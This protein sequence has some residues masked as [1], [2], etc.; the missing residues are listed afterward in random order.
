MKRILILL[1]VLCALCVSCSEKETLVPVTGLEIEQETINIEVGQSIRL[2]AVITPLDASD[3]SV[4][5]LSEK[6]KIVTVDQD[7]VI[8][9]VKAGMARIGVITADEKYYDLCNV[10]VEDVYGED[11]IP[12]PVFMEC[13]LAAT[14]DG[15]DGSEKIDAN[16][17]GRISVSEAQ[18]VTGI[19]VAGM[20]IADMKGLDCFPGLL[21]LDC[22]GI[23]AA[24]IDFSGNSGLVSINCRDGELETLF[25]VGF[26]S[27]TDLDCSGN[28]IQ[29]LNL[30][31]LSAIKSLKCGRQT[32]ASGAD[33]EVELALNNALYPS[34]RMLKQD[35]DNANVKLLGEEELPEGAIF[36]AEFLAKDEDKTENEYIIYGVITSAENLETGEITISDGTGE[37]YVHYLFADSQA[38]DDKNYG[39]TKELG[40]EVG[41][42]VVISGFRAS[43]S[44]KPCVWNACCLEHRKPS[45]EITS[46]RDFIAAEVDDT[47]EYMIKGTVTANSFDFYY[48]RIYLD[49]G[50]GEI[51]V[52]YL[53]ADLDAREKMDYGKT[54]GLNIQV[55]DQIAIKGYRGDLSGIPCMT[56]GYCVEIEHVN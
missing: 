45:G 55:G 12:D 26:N 19:N 27:L 51:Y 8:T 25:L 21:T 52:N 46:I 1:S 13:L 53:F 22:R 17:S 35:P 54:A 43:R 28:H 5:W 29:K 10:V 14:V 32:D 7:G 56:N 20:D 33:L 4:V 47:V 38:R 41:D 3:K 15:L 24:K 49:D 23:K 34:W 11:E 44:G 16:G 2:D 42:V 31:S 18:R 6:N 40:L 30:S 39:P 48:G 9:G 50:T 36:I 37:V